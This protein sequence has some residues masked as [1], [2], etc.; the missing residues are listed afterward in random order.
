M[1]GMLLTE[2]F[3]LDAKLLKCERCDTEEID[4]AEGVFGDNGVEG[5][6]GG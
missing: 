3:K 4:D 6:V 2:L 5:G 1:F